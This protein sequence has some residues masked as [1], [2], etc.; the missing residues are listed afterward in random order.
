MISVLALFACGGTD[1]DQPDADA[2]APPVSASVEEGASA[3]EAAEP[4]AAA[5]PAAAVD[6]RVQS[7]LDLIRQAEFQSALPVCLAAL[8]IDPDNAQVREAVETAR[9][10]TAKA[11][12]A[13][14]AGEAGA[15]G[16]A[17]E[18]TSQLGEAAGKL[19]E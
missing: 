9:A 16:A 4:E 8:E 13:G 10:E 18:A 1:T 5:E 17:A 11:A 12:A 3:P 2:G 7:C 15:E 6:P 14:A 19:S